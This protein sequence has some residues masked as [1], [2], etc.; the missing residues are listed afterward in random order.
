MIFLQ[1]LYGLLLT[2]K[3]QVKLGKTSQKWYAALLSGERKHRNL[4]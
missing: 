3:L 2:V 4:N 1:E